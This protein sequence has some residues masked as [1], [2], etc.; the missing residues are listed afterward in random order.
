MGW[1]AAHESPW[2]PPR[3]L[4]LIDPHK[5]KIDTPVD[6]RG[7]ID[8]SQL[9]T[10]VKAT[11]DSSYVWPDGLSVH[12]LYWPGSAY[13]HE[14]D[15]NAVDASVFRNLPIHK[16]LL[17]RVFENWL[18]RITLPPDVPDPEVMQYRIEAWNIA[19]DLFQS[20]RETVLHDKL[21]RQR[22]AYITTNPEVLKAEFNGEDRI[23][24]EY[25]QS[26]YEKNFR[27]WEYV[28][29]RHE[30]IPEEFRLLQLDG[31]PEVLARNLGKLVVPRSL[32]LV[33][34]VAGN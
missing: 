19:K 7:I 34:A 14:N 23:G 33:R 27:G 32:Q 6:A 5:E 2:L 3:D 1:G 4:Q 8:I 18:H 24:E 13:S 28:C 11:V 10:N 15:E 17:P 26:E 25:I 30:R 29:K 12:H 31:P 22:R 20:A 21:T 16:A 9:V